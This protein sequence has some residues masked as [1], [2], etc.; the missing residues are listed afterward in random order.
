MRF[1]CFSLLT[2]AMVFCV[3]DAN[4]DIFVGTYLDSASDSNAFSGQDGQFTVDGSGLSA[5]VNNGD[6]LASALTVTHSFNDT[7]L[8]SYVTNDNGV[9]YFEAGPN[10]VLTPVLVFDLGRDVALTDIVLWQ[11]QNNGGNGSASQ[12]NAL[13]SFDVRINSSADGSGTFAGAATSLEAQTVGFDLN[14]VNSAQQLSFSGTGRFIQFTLID[15]HRGVEDVNSGGDRVGL[16][17][18]RF[19]GIAAVPEPSSVAFLSLG[20]FGL[21]IRRRQ[22]FSASS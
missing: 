7:I 21:F 16:G 11:Y 8:D 17:E 9:D 3:C 6:S 13:F 15:N 20:V 19:N 12:G 5:A 10:P 14:G 4:A 2:V 22:T 18:V 1:F